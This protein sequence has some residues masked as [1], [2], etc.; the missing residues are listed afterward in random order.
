MLLITSLLVPS[1]M[2]ESASTNCLGRPSTKKLTVITDK[3]AMPI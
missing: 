2:L 3:D 1:D